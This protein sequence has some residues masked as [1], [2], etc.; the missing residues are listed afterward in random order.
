MILTILLYPSLK[1]SKLFSTSEVPHQDETNND[2]RQEKNNSFYRNSEKKN[3]APR[4]V[5]LTKL[6]PRDRIINKNN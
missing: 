6:R 3:M 1:T 5:R 2:D 4:K